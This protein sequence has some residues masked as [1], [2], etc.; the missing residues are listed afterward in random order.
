[1]NFLIIQEA[2]RHP[3]NAR[4]RECLSMQRALEAQGHGV[5]V[6]GLGYTEPPW[7]IEIYRS[8][9][10]IV[11]LEEYDQSD[12][13]PNLSSASAFKVMWARDTHCKGPGYHRKMHQRDGYDLILQST[14]SLVGAISDKDVW[15]P[16][17]Y[18]AELCY[19]HGYEFRKWRI[20]FCGNVLNRDTHLLALRGG[21]QE[22]LTIDKMVLGLAMR[23][24]V[25]SY[26]VHFNRNISTDIN[27][28]N[29]ETI[30][31]GTALLV[32]N[33]NPQAYAHLGFKDEEN[34]VYYTGLD[35]LI[36]RAE[37]AIEHWERIG[38]AGLELAK[39]HTYD[40]RCKEMV[41][42]IKGEM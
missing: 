41:E 9:D 16:N 36:E 25:A 5:D 27:Y 2:G 29:F 28:R 1:M 40:Q 15:F 11:Q 39:R 12:W 14:P 26:K 17:C 32:E 21:Y 30:G 22:H 6:W 42:L 23:D 3:E 4:W 10:V 20:G 8:F 35:D 37:Y 31:C 19:V 24:A 34:V 7:S 33:N 38:K 13:L 18:D